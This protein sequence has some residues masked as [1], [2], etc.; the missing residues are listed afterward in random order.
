MTAAGTLLLVGCSLPNDNAHFDNLPGF[1]CEF[2]GIDLLV[3]VGTYD[4]VIT[5]LDEATPGP[6]FAIAIND[7]VKRLVSRYASVGL[8]I[9]NIE[10]TFHDAQKTVGTGM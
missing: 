10:A 8:Q 1:Y 6:I 4:L 9:D 3:I 2:Q 5:L 7:V